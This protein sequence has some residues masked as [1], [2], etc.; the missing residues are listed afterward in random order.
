MRQLKAKDVPKLRNHL[1]KEQDVCCA[2]C[3]KK[4]TDPCLDHSHVKKLKGTG[5]IRGVLCRTC[6]VFLAK[7]ENNCIRFNITSSDL[8]RILRNCAKYLERKHLPYIHPSER[9][10]D[11]KLKKQAYNKLR[12]LYETER[13][14]GK[15]MRKFPE[16]PKSGKLTK[17]LEKWFYE[18]GIVPDFYK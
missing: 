5:Q 13:A 15:R 7:S 12:K 2:I 9:E 11:P 14:T 4:T 10:K 6:N 18:L 3:K 8:P 17:E 1:L 16:Y